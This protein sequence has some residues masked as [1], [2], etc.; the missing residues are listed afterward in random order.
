MQ[1]AQGVA[2]YSDVQRLAADVEEVVR[3]LKSLVP[4]VDRIGTTIP[5][6]CSPRFALSASATPFRRPC[7]GIFSSWG[8]A[9]RR[10]CCVMRGGVDNP[11]SRVPSCAS[12]Q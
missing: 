5:P 2:G 4:K 6:F 3:E 11:V 10:V 9:A 7:C 1:M 12:L 8:N